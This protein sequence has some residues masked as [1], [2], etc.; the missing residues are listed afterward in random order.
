[1]NGFEYDWELIEPFFRARSND[2]SRQKGTLDLPI[3]STPLSK[4]AEKLCPNVTKAQLKEALFGN[5]CLLCK[6]SSDDS[7]LALHRKDGMSHNPEMIHRKR[8]LQ[9][10]DPDEWALVRA[11]FFRAPLPVPAYL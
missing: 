11:Y 3:D 8:Y 6:C 7:T 4:E 10:L 1:M 9:R 5:T 2:E